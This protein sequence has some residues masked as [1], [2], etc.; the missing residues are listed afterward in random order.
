VGRESDT[1]ARTH[2]FHLFDSLMHGHALGVPEVAP[3]ATPSDLVR[4]VLDRNEAHA[5]PR[6][7]WTIPSMAI[8]PIHQGMGFCPQLDQAGMLNLDLETINDNDGVDLQ[9]S[10]D[11]VSNCTKSAGFA[12]KME[13]AGVLDLITTAVQ[14]RYYTTL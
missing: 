4:A 5:E 11:S 2:S 13:R 3:D 14:S 1:R 6:R 10:A 12:L 9:V 7:S 8:P